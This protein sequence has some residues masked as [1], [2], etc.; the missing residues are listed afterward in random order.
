MMKG[1]R[2]RELT[3]KDLRGACLSKILVMVELRREMKE[4]GVEGVGEV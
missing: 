1:L 2:G 4:S 3:L